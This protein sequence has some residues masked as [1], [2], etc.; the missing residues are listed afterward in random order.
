MKGSSK[1]LKTK[2]GKDYSMSSPTCGV[3]L[4]LPLFVIVESVPPSK[5]TIWNDKS[6]ICDNSSPMPKLSKTSVADLTSNA[7]GFAPYWTDL[8]EEISSKLLLPVG[9]DCV[10]SD[11]SCFN[12]WWNKTV[13][14]SWFRA[15]L[16]TAPNLNSQP[17]FSPSFTSSLVECTDLEVTQNRS[18]KIRIF[19]DASQRQILR[20]WFG[21]S[22]YV[23]NQT[24]AYLQQ[25]DTVAN[26][27]KLKKQILDSLPEWAK[28]VPFQIKSIAIKDACL[29]VKKAKKDYK[30]D[31]KPR[32]MKFRSRRDKKQ[33]IYIPKSAIKSQGIYHT[34]LGKV[35]YKED[36]PKEFSDGRLICY[37]DEYYVIVSEK[38]QPINAEN[39][40]RVVSL[41]PGVRK[42]FAFFSETS[43]GF[44]GQGANLV[45]EKLCFKLDKLV[46]KITKAK[47]KQKRRLKKAADKLRIK[48]QN[49]VSELHHKIAHFL[50]TNFDVILLPTFETSQMVSKSKRK[51]RSKSVR[52]MLTLSHY[53]FKEF[54][55]WKVW[56]HGKKLVEVCEAYTSKTVSWTGEIVKVGGSEKIKSPSTGITLDRDLN[57]A[58]GVFLRAVV[59]TPW[60]REYLNFSIC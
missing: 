13:E 8:C 36:L 57:G 42:M 1:A 31:G 7:K 58:R 49:L 35:T 44:L 28:S 53:R 26:W 46:S 11:S 21:V 48:I 59:D 15:K 50:V 27:Y 38:M 54:L 22:R 30:K 12:I 2:Q 29:A 52:Q 16:Y 39:Q 33:S 9:I 41:D 17:I 60:L 40:G 3:Q 19:L 25:P 5:E 47:C 51:I 56:Q 20:H 43:F 55:R 34:I 24:I 37:G 18:R 32:K 10:D 23:Y 45:I 4:E 14:N 6:N